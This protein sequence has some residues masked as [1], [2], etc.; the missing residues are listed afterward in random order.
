QLGDQRPARALPQAQGDVDRERAHLGLLPDA[1]ARPLLHDAHVRLSLAQAQAQ[2]I[3]A[4]DVLLLA[5][6]GEAAR[7]L[8]PRGDVQDDQRRDPADVVVGLPALGLRPTERDLRPAVPERNR[9]PQ[10]PRRHRGQ[11]VRARSQAG[12]EDSVTAGDSEVTDLTLRNAMPREYR[13]KGRQRAAALPLATG[14]GDG[15]AEA[16]GARPGRYLATT[17]R[18]SCAMALSGKRCQTSSLP[19]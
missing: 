12:E 7:P 10:H 9:P 4:R 8:D 17:A 5:A 1:A 11:G 14:A 13:R 6:D 19:S 16:A 18:S 2:R 3:Y 15:R